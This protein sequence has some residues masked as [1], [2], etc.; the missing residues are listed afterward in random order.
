VKHI[1]AEFRTSPQKNTDEHGGDGAGACSSG[2]A[3]LPGG[4][5]RHICHVSATCSAILARALPIIANAVCARL[6]RGAA[7]DKR[8]RRYR[9]AAICISLEKLLAGPRAG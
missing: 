4:N 7:R 2:P 6:T 1:A 9:S 5:T 3:P 8:D